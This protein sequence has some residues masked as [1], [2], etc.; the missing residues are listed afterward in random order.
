MLKQI[1]HAVLAAI[2]L[3]GATLRGGEAAELKSGVA[4]HVCSDSPKP[5]LDLAATGRWVVHAICG[6][7]EVTAKAR[8][9]FT[10]ARVYGL[11]SAEH[12]AD[13]RSLPY[14]SRIVNTLIVDDWKMRTGVGPL[15]R[16]SAL[17]YQQIRWH[18]FRMHPVFSP[19]GGVAALGHRLHAAMPPA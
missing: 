16:T 19:T 13:L 6:S 9:A 12:R 18:P 5:G 4:V 1:S 10:E 2:L 17:I 3:I 8:A 11:A 7:P 15:G 14:A